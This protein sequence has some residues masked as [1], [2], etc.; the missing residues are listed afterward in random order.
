MQG[1]R[2]EKT[3]GMSQ[4]INAGLGRDTRKERQRGTQRNRAKNKRKTERK[5]KRDG[6]Q[7]NNVHTYTHLLRMEDTDCLDTTSTI[8]VTFHKF[9]AKSKNKSQQK[10]QKKTDN[11]FP[12]VVIV[13][14]I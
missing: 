6:G 4:R 3:E 14:K 12:T 2:V 13:A 1:D 8:F 11:H 9:F 10:F 5:T 7:L